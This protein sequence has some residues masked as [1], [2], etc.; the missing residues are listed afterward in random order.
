[1]NVL[2]VGVDP[3]TVEELHTRIKRLVLNRGRG[4]VL[5][6]N[7]HCLNILHEDAALR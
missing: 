4:T 1:M 2:G 6:V 7:A 5:N 3:V